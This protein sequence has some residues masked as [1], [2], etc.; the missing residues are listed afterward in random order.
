MSLWVC[1]K[2]NDEPTD[3]EKI[4]VVD[5]PSHSLWRTIKPIDYQGNYSFILK[6]HY[7]QCN[8]PQPPE[9]W[10]D[11]SEQCDFGLGNSEVTPFQHFPYQLKCN[12]L[13]EWPRLAKLEGYRLRKVRLCWP[14]SLPTHGKVIGDY[15]WAFIVE[16][17]ESA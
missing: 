4:E 12:T 14:E 7:R 3:E 13:F 8:P 9:R 1:S 16:K 17:K 10:V 2:W 5:C 11:V 6:S 15:Q